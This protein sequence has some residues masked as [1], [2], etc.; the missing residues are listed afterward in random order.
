MFKKQNGITLVALIITIIVM[1]IL[2]GV[3]I[4]L[5]VGEN[6]VLT[7]AQNAGD[8]TKRGEAQQAIE[9]AF[10]DLLMQYYD[11]NNDDAYTLSKLETAIKDNGNYDDDVKI[12][13]I[14]DFRY[15]FNDKSDSEKV[16]MVGITGDTDADYH[17]TQPADYAAFVSNKLVTYTVAEL[18][19]GS[20][21]A[22][23]DVTDPLEYKAADDGEPKVY[24]ADKTPTA[25]DSEGEV[26]LRVAI[27]SEGNIYLFDVQIEVKNGKY[28]AT[29]V[30][31]VPLANEQ[32]IEIK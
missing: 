5:V 28:Q 3:S 6:G 9:L 19:K 22:K 26:D 17:V 11:G 4:S 30:T 1:L 10:A 29:D 20:N 31:Y 8:A 23:F 32:S 15:S 21:I 12:G 7:Q 27:K 18:N 13:F 16:K 2:A 24:I 25:V 14:G